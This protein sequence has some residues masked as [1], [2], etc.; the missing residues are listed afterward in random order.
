[1][2]DN[3]Y[4]RVKK[5]VMSF[6]IPIV[7]A[8]PIT[9]FVGWFEKYVFGDWEFLKF[10]VV[11]MIVDTLMGFLHHIKKDVYKRQVFGYSDYENTYRYI[12]EAMIR[13]I[14]GDYSE[15]KGVGHCVAKPKDT[16][17]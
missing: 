4:N 14:K 11:L 12:L 6:Y 8:I 5:Y 15:I 2:Y 9:P 3:F 17:K 16:N 13:V 10:L 7:V 1:M